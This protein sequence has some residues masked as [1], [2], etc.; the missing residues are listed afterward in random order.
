[1]LNTPSASGTPP[2][3]S[4]A[5]RLSLPT[6]QNLINGV[7]DRPEDNVS[8]PGWHTMDALGE[9]I[10]QC[11]FISMIPP[12]RGDGL[13]PAPAWMAEQ[14]R[15]FRRVGRIGGVGVDRIRPACATLNWDRHESHG[16]SG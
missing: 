11:I 13:P 10:I 16:A 7:S 6:I 5:L 2:T 9:V 3:A 14:S 15:P 4:T 1:M 8:A 12:T